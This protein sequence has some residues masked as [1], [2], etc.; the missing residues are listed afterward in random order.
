VQKIS[1]RYLA[2]LAMLAI[3]LPLT[4]CGPSSSASG[5]PA[6]GGSASAAA[7]PGSGRRVPMQTGSGGEFVSPSGNI[8][9]EVSTTSVMCETN[10]PARSAT[11][12]SSGS[13]KVCDGDSCL[14]NAGDGTP[15]LR[16]GQSTGVG[17]FTCS[18]ASSG[19]TCEVNG[20]GFVISASGISAA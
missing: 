5:A 15:T 20:K 17:P 14:G 1:G 9:C 12:G 18:S 10:S 3:A 19:V 11:M 4:A 6:Q 16:Y 13:Y 7:Q 8:S 2:G